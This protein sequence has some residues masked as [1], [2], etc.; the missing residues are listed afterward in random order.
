[1]NRAS[2]IRFEEIVFAYPGAARAA[3]QSIELSI[4]PGEIV[5]L[6]GP[7]G[8]GKSTLLRIV[9]GLI[10]PTSGRLLIDERDATETPAHKR[11]IGWVPQSYALFEHLNVSDNIGF[12]LRM[13][14]A[15]KT[16]QSKVVREMLALCRIEDLATRNVNDISGGQRQRVAIARALAVRPRV[17]L[18]DEPL[19]ALDPQLRAALRTDLEQLLR[20]TGVTTLFV[21][22]DQGEALALAD[23]VAVLRDGRLEQF[24]TPEHVW[25]QPSNAFVA[26]FF[27]ADVVGCKVVGNREVEIAP[28]VVGAAAHRLTG[29]ESH[30]V[31]RRSDWVLDGKG[32]EL[33]V[34]HCEYAGGMFYLQGV[35]PDSQRINLISSDKIQAGAIVR[36]G[37]RGDAQLHTVT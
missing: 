6:V 33:A 24:D 11:H 26:G 21:T 37:L 27:G 15:G 32:V 3:L 19:A 7:S 8:C 13:Q 1:M 5:T 30:V 17:L 12:G 29:S 35:L 10:A 31:V 2:P 22:H 34:T 20:A 23:R 36:V 4:N 25:S 28:G 14:G 18:L 16:E 9:A